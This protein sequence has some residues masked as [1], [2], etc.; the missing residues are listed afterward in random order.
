MSDLA[1]SG[2]KP[3]GR[4]QGFIEAHKRKINLAAN[5]GAA[6]FNGFTFTEG[7]WGLTGINVE[8]MERVSGI[9]SKIATGIQG[10][11]G[12]VDN[13]TKENIIPLIGN[14]L[15]VPIAILASGYN[16][17]LAR[18]LSQGW[19]QFQGIFKHRLLETKDGTKKLIGDDFSKRGSWATGFKTNI[20]E[21]PK[22]VKEI[23]TNPFA[24][25]Q[26]FSRGVF[27]CSFVQI[28]GALTSF[29]GFEKLGAGLRDFGGSIVD[30]AFMLDKNYVPAGIVW[31]G[32]AIV[33]FVK[34][35]TDKIP[36]L[37]ELS[38]FFDRAASVFFMFANFA[39]EED[40]SK[41]IS[42]EELKTLRNK[43][44]TK[45]KNEAK[46]LEKAA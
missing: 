42:Y 46:K 8:L 2:V 19:V 12:A 16:L 3:L 25:E 36:N 34:R 18:G 33:D 27:T 40:Q 15:E 13:S 7:N 6:L 44:K 11:L 28:V 29:T 30:F 39:A 21:L 41:I 17:W 20:A 24:R 22:I 45:I 43:G 37:T 10:V 1:I 32:A 4:V 14:A 5:G 31:V 9:F 26:G 38:L 23:F 35:F